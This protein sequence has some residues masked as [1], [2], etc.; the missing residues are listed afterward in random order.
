MGSK[1]IWVWHGK[2]L[3]VKKFGNGT[4]EYFGWGVIWGVA[5]CSVGS[6]GNIFEW[7]QGEKFWGGWQKNLGSN[8]LGVTWQKYFDVYLYS[9]CHMPPPPTTT[10][11]HCFSF[12]I[13]TF[14]HHMCAVL[15]FL[16][17]FDCQN[18][19]SN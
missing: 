10:I 4:A 6:G 3:G 8:I 18:L 11:C 1:K 14:L 7:S 15:H 5:N 2:I 13:S 16:I 9:C 12:N 19:H 17:F